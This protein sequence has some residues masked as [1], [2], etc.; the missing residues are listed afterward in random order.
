MA[1]TLP[2]IFGQQKPAAMTETNLFSVSL[3][4]QAQFSI[5]VCNQSNVIDY[6]TIALIPYGTNE[7]GASYITYQTPLSGN[8]IFSI[9]SLDLNSGDRVNVASVNGTTSFTATGI[10]IGP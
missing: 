5:F 6:F 1:T 3:T 4:N 9:S 8:S 7:V 2:R 10:D